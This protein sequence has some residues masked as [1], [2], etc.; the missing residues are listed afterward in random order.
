M[1]DKS[2]Y[3]VGM[4]LHGSSGT[5][6]AG[7]RNPARRGSHS[8]VRGPGGRIA[9]GAGDCRSAVRLGTAG[10]DANSITVR[11]MFNETAEYRRLDVVALNGG[12]FIALKDAPGPCPGPGWQLLPSVTPS[13]QIPPAVTVSKWLLI[14]RFRQCLRALV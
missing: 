11:G 3:Q 2:A 13:S 14:K 10:R 7:K 12:S 5:V 6:A 8:R 1:V 9:G 4:H